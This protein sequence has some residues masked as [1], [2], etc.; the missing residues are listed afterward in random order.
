MQISKYLVA[1]S[2]GTLLKLHIQ[3]RASRTEISGVQEDSLKIRIASPPVEGEANR[4]CIRFL[5]K[6]LGIPKSQI[7]IL[8]GQK[9]RHKVVLI[10]NNSPEDIMRAFHGAGIGL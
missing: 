5:S 2:E 10:R 7:A 4:E 8:Q 1:H 3:P 9:S 6:I